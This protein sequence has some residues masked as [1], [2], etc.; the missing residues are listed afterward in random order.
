MQRKSTR[1]RLVLI[2]MFTRRGDSRIARK[3]IRN[4]NGR[5]VN[6]PYKQISAEI[7]FPLPI[8]V[9]MELTKSLALGERWRRSRRRG[10]IVREYPLSPAIAGALPQGEP[11]DACIFR[12]MGFARCPRC[13]QHCNTKAKLAIKRNDK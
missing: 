4:D 2:R 7:L 12:G 5:F 10:Q 9:I 11:L 6:H 8:C 1:F 13:K 3:N